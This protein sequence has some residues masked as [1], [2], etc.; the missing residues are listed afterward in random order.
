[1]PPSHVPFDH[2]FFGGR[3]RWLRHGWSRYLCNNS[4]VALNGWLW[5]LLSLGSYALW[6][7]W[8]NGWHLGWVLCGD[9]STARVTSGTGPF[10]TALAVLLPHGLIELPAFWIAWALAL[11]TGSAWLWPLPGSGRWLSLKRQLRRSAAVLPFV[12]LMLL[13]AA[14]LEAYPARSVRSR[15][16]G[17]VGISRQLRLEEV[18]L[19]DV[20]YDKPDIGLP[21]ISP[22]GR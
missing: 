13:V 1:M 2:W 21:A 22:A 16:L 19:G 14:L 3:A 17:G 10:G 20:M 15:Y 11:R 5:S 4:L 12:V 6:G 9:L 18:I 8:R 7:S